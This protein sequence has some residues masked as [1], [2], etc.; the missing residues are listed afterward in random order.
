M[1]LLIVLGILL[2]ISI[3]P[4]GIRGRYDERGAYLFLMIGPLVF[5][6][7]PRKERKSD[8]ESHTKKAKKALDKP[9]RKS[10][11]ISDFMVIFRVIFDILQD[12]RRKIRVNNL[13]LHIVLAGGDPCDLAV[14]YGKA[15][16]AVGNLTPLLERALVIKGRDMQVRC[17]FEAE[18]TVIRASIDLTM[19]VGRLLAL[20]CC[21]GVRFLKK[22]FKIVNNAKDGALL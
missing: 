17:D 14:N 11:G 15:W 10:G 22:Y 8:K 13:C 18:K 19:T 7:Y 5:T 4:L 2:L 20:V 6:L 16:A 1:T 12:L 3:I 9:K 21:H